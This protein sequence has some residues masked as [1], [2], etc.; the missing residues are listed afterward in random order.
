[1]KIHSL[2]VGLLFFSSAYS[3]KATNVLPSTV[4]QVFSLEKGDSLEYRIWT[5]ANGCG[6]IC[7][8]F[9]LKTVDS[10]NYSSAQDTLFIFF[11]T[12]LIR[13]DTGAPVSQC[14]HCYENFIFGDICPVPASK[15]VIPNLDTT[16]THLLDT[17]YDG[18]YGRRVDS[19][20]INPAAYNGSKQNFYFLQQDDLY[21]S[22]DQEIYVDSIGIVF[23]RE[24]IQQVNNNFQQLIYYHKAN[25]KRWGSSFFEVG[26]NDLP[27]EESFF[28]YPNPTEGR[29]MIHADSYQGIEF[30]L[31]DALS[32]QVMNLRLTDNETQ[33]GRNNL[34][35]GIYFWQ[36]AA[37]ADVIKTGKL[38]IK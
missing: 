38:V 17:T 23:K 21:F 27:R 33:V 37:G 8:W 35:A 10:I 19:A 22:Y 9:E 26:I 28:I 34:S 13:F 3:V 5:V 6:T 15:W 29:F 2:I 20:Y 7:N 14:G 36:M 18:Y 24:A 32:R 25:G 31:L 4:R 11:N 1:M 30:K 16:I 12:E